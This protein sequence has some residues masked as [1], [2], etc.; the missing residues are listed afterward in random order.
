MKG[1]VLLKENEYCKWVM[2]LAQCRGMK[3]LEWMMAA[4][5]SAWNP[6]GSVCSSHFSGTQEKMGT[7]ISTQLEKL[8]AKLWQP[9]GGK[10]CS[11]LWARRHTK[12]KILPSSICTIG[13]NDVSCHLCQEHQSTSWPNCPWHNP[14]ALYLGAKASRWH[15]ERAGETWTTKCSSSYHK[16]GRWNH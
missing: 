3:W 16:M 2:N 13:L 7:S 12:P 9:E 6:T 5:K 14:E 8:L 15:S 4:R 11:W 10:T 1:T